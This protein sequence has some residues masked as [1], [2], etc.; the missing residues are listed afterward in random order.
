MTRTDNGIVKMRNKIQTAREVKQSW[1]PLTRSQGRRLV[2]YATRYIHSKSVS[3]TLKLDVQHT[4]ALY[5]ITVATMQHPGYC[6]T[7]LLS[8]SDGDRNTVHLRTS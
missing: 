8:L 1:T 7:V 6:T 4:T 5:T 3:Y 2:S